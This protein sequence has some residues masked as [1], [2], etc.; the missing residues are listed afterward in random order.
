MLWQVLAHGGAE[1]TALAWSHD[2]DLL[3]SSGEDDIIRVW[4]GVT[5]QCLSTIEQ[6]AVDRL[7]WSSSGTLAASCGGVIHL[8]P[9]AST[10]FQAA[11]A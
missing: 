4:Q 8:L 9:Q 2:G 1:I 10:C 3:A 5:G 7:Q 11:A 6:D